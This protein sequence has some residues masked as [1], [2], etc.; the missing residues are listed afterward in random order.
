MLTLT[1]GI[2]RRGL[3]D[4]GGSNADQTEIPET[5]NGV[6]WGSTGLMHITL[7]G[8]Q[9]VLAGSQESYWE[10]KRGTGRVDVTMVTAI[11]GDPREQ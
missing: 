4:P 6:K 9:T 7:W 2:L 11:L 8:G 10:H 5:N 3:R 1:L